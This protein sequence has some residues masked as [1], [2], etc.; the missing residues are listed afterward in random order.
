M[1]IFRG[2]KIL[3][4][5]LVVCYMIRWWVS[6]GDYITPYITKVFTFDLYVNINI[7][8]IALHKF[9]VSAITCLIHV[10]KVWGSFLYHG[11]FVHS[12][13]TVM[14]RDC[15]TSV[16]NTF[17]SVLQVWFLFWGEERHMFTLT[18]CQSNLNPY[19][20]GRK[21]AFFSVGI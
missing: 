19:Y 2:K 7:F 17:S 3:Q 21:A 8:L 16:K 20:M 18:L 11:S 15:T 12:Y 4:Q 9:H 5:N 1:H 6:S 13:S 10:C 14:F